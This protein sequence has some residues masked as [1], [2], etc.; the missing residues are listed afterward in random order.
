MAC[1]GRLL[2]FTIQH[3][4]EPFGVRNEAHKSMREL[5]AFDSLRS[6]RFSARESQNGKANLPEHRHQG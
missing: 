6:S 5:T 3:H 1:R 4:V 2:N